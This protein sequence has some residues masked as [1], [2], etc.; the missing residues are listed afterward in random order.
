MVEVVNWGPRTVDVEVRSCA[1]LST[2]HGDKAV[3]ELDGGQGACVR[4][5]LRGVGLV[6]PR[7]SCSPIGWG[8]LQARGAFRGTVMDV[9]VHWGNVVAVKAHSSSL[10]V[11]RRKLWRE[12]GVSVGHAVDRQDGWHHCDTLL[13]RS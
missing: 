2:A 10:G 6:G 3:P 13:F 4:A 8:P 12:P 5:C 11:G 7:V 9:E 1:R